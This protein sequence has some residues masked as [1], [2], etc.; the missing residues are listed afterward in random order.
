MSKC[1]TKV[2]IIII[3]SPSSPTS[4]EMNRSTDKTLPN[5]LPPSLVPFPKKTFSP[6]FLFFKMGAP[7]WS[8]GSSPVQLQ[9]HPKEN[10]PFLS[11]PLP[12]SLPNS[13][14]PRILPLPFLLR[15]DT[16]IL[17][18]QYHVSTCRSLY[19]TIP[20][21]YWAN[22]GTTPVLY[23]KK[24]PTIKRIYNLKKYRPPSFLPS[25]LRQAHPST[26]PS[27]ISGT[28]PT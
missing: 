27:K 18:V 13:S 21:N 28:L 8:S 11:T 2:A 5:P 9:T 12:P 25:F 1:P 3:S 20:P 23:I 19:S 16:G 26:H 15:Y 10:K 14:Q 24:T 22:T 6:S 17:Q 7:V 4:W